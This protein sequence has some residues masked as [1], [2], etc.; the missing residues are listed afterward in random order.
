VRYGW[1]I[2]YY[3]TRNPCGSEGLIAAGSALL[4]FCH[5]KSSRWCLR[6]GEQIGD[7]LAEYGGVTGVVEMEY[8]SWK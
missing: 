5:G 2:L 8:K 4:S 1:Q 3:D 7:G 6:W